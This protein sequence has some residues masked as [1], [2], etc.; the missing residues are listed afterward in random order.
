MNTRYYSSLAY[1][2]FI[3]DSAKSYIAEGIKM[4][5]NDVVHVVV[6]KIPFWCL[7]KAK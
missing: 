7:N 4:S 2:L 6:L 3:Q 5:N 1:S